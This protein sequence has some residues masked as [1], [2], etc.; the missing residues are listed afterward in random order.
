MF[1]L[2]IALVYSALAASTAFAQSER[3]SIQGADIA[4]WNLAGRMRAVAGSG[5]AVEVEVTRAGADASRLRIEAGRVGNRE[6]LRVVYPSDRI[7]YPGPGRWRTDVSVRDDGTFDEGWGDWRSRDRVTIRSSGEG[8]EAHA[9]LLVSVPKG[10]RIALYLAAGRVEVV[11]VDGDLA[12]DVGAAEVDVSGTKGPLFLDA[13]SGRVTVRDVA[14]DVNVDAGSGSITLERIKGGVLELDSGSGSI[15]AAEIEVRDFRADVGSGGVTARR[16]RAA[17]VTI[18]SGSGSC[19]VEL[20]GELERMT[21]ESGSGGVTVR[22]PAEFSAEIDAETGSGGFQTDFE[23]VTRRLSRNHMQGRI[24][25]GKARVRI[26][27]GSG[28]IRLLKS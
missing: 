2:P 13:G 7:V 15:E 8:L 20:V 17:T 16:L 11:N 28:T 22:A 6:T 10:Q 14:G 26:E 4:I 24:R 5:S 3:R 23:I 18:D 12:I 9:D 25:D 27:S 1:R 19:H 21:V